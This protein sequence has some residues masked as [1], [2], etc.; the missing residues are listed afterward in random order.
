MPAGTLVAT[1][2]FT[3][4]GHGGIARALEAALERRAW[5]RGAA[6]AASPS[7]AAAAVSG[8]ASAAAPNAQVGVASASVAGIDLNDLNEYE[9]EQVCACWQEGATPFIP[10]SPPT[11]PCA[12]A[13]RSRNVQAADGRPRRACEQMRALGLHVTGSAPPQAPPPLL[14]HQQPQ[15]TPAGSDA[16]EGAAGMTA[17]EIEQLRALGVA[18]PGDEAAPLPPP[19]TPVPAPPSSAASSAPVP[20]F[21]TRSAGVSGI[22]RQQSMEEAQANAS[23]SEAFTDLSSLME[24]ARELVALADKMRGFERR[25]TAASGAG[26]EDAAEAAA[27]A[28]M[29]DFLL[30]L[31]LASPVT[32]TS[33]GSMYHQ[34]LSRQLADFLPRVL[35]NAGGLMA[36]PEVY[37]VYNRARG[38]ELVS[39]AD[40]LQACSLWETL[41]LPLSLQTFGGTPGDG[42]KGGVLCVC[43]ARFSQEDLH[44][45]LVELA[46]SMGD[47]S[48]GLSAEDAAMVLACPPAVTREMLR[49][50]EGTGKLCRDEAGAGV[51]RWHR[52][53]FA[54]IR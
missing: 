49:S 17:Y 29:G 37:C 25:D 33:A 19:Q 54:D 51:V 47:G 50:A 18:I 48:E 31:G 53:F 45:R 23:V 34:E 2:V 36:L 42:D 20:S 14:P 32:K 43:A 10:T 9:I 46:E 16:T 39:P 52:N 27:T 35:D 15:T 26:A 41:G 4:K 5:E 24:H 13:Y 44:A 21:T 6:A 8:A 38:S 12:R 22:I 28:E 3:Q 40:L 1:F 7:P 30:T 11:R